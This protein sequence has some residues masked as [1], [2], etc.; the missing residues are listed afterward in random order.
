LAQYPVQMLTLS[1]IHKAYAGRVLLSDATLQL[2]AGDRIGLVGPN[3]AGKSTLF[4]MIL[5]EEEPDQGGVV[6][7]RGVTV[8]YL[9]Q[10]SAPVEDETVLEVAISASRELLGLWRRLNRGGE[11]E[12]DH[13]AKQEFDALDGYR[14][15]A[16]ARQILSGLSFREED[17]ERAARTLSGGWVMRAH[18]AKLLVQAP[19]LLLL[20]E[21]TNHLDL[22]ALLWFQEHLKGYRGGI[23]VISHDR[24]FLNQLVGSIVEI[25]QS[26]L[27]RY[28]GNYESFVEQRQATEEQLLAAYKNQQREIARLQ[29]FADRFRAKN[30]KASQAQSKLKQI[31]RMEKIEAPES[32]APRLSFQFPQPQRSGQRVIRLGGVDFSYGEKVVYRGMNFEVERGQRVVLVGPNGA[33]KSTLLKLAAGV[34]EVQGGERV[35]GYNVKA[36]YFSQYRT[37]VLDESSTVLE[38]AL[39]TPQALSVES[40]RTVLGSFLFRG[41]D[42]FKPVRV[43]SGGE[44][45]RLALVK[46]LLDPPNLML[47]DEPT[48]HLDIPS[49]EALLAALHKYEGTILFISHDVYFIRQLANHVVHVRDGKLTLYSGNYDYY[50]DRTGWRPE[51]AV[52]GGGV[53]SVGAG[54]SKS[55]RA[56]EKREQKRLEAEERKRLSRLRKELQ[57]GVDALEKDIH[58]LETRQAELTE[59]MEDPATYSDAER[60][61]EVQREFAANR[62]R[63]EELTGRWEDLA[64]QLEAVGSG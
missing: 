8:G 57:S 15:V 33:G 22:E 59:A 36:G 63:L 6:F 51:V 19:D 32:E 17:H 28:R 7:Q 52:T 9:P 21:P 11:G 62:A 37:D 2:V 61:V 26:K 12:E 31:E 53:E 5:G 34:L 50:V 64:G 54:G 25:R 56:V 20:D 18:L 44:K 10:E 29:D 42:V 55:G 38:E 45:S 14:V 4:R 46:L 41:D 60:A 40:V 13:E 47:L 58:E 1:G 48:T 27:F 16:K 35:L 49:T 30:T 3:G 24:E 23:L 43:L 39:D